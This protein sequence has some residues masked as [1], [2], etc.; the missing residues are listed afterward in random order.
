MGGN[1][2]S[3]VGRY[4]PDPA[5]AFRQEQEAE[6]ARDDHGFPGRTVEELWRDREW[7]EYIYTGGTATV[8][9]QSIMVEPTD[10]GGG[11]YMR[12]LTDAEIRA[13]APD[14]RPTHAAWRAALGSDRLPFPGRAC[15][16]CTVLFDDDGPAGMAYWGV[17]A[18]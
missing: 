15:G 10:T 5:A 2:W 13:W 3:H 12:P 17:T 4:Q 9:D 11:P 14:G 6:L 7:M 1:A 18:D 8:L 16:N